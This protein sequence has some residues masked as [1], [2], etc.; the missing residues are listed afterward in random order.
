MKK[1][2]KRMNEAANPAQQA[3]IAIDMKKKGKKPKNVKE[4][5]MTPSE[6]RKDTM[7]KKK[8]DKS[9]MKKSMQDQYGKEEGK[10]VYFA[11]IRKQAMKKEEYVSE[12]SDMSKLNYMDA[13]NKQIQKRA[14]GIERAAMT[15]GSIKSCLLYTSDA[16]DD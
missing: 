13:A 6:K 16:A 2:T 15:M 1:K 12:I 11:T 7:L 4:E 5:K 9:D 8:Y 10:K 14:K 3:A